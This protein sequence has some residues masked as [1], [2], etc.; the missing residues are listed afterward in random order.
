MGSLITI[1]RES[2]ASIKLSI[3]Q[4][5]VI[6][7]P[8][9]FDNV[10]VIITD[11]Y[12]QVVGKYSIIQNAGEG[13]DALTIVDSKLNFVLQ[14]DQTKDA[15]LSKLFSEVRAIKLDDTQRSGK[16][17]TIAKRKEFAV[18]DDSDS[19]KLIMPAL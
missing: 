11:S 7:N 18:I 4:A 9:I 13:F 3:K 5:G 2:T 19:S 16:W 17:N 10:V 6:V 12:G 14:S 1:P 8:S 15:Q